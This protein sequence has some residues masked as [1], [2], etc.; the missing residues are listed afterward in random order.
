MQ[1]VIYIKDFKGKK[2][3][4]IDTVSNNVAHGLFELGVAEK[5]SRQAEKLLRRVIK[6]EMRR[7]PKDKMMRAEVKTDGR[8]DKKGRYITK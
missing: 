5:Y 7:P 8:K 4:N 2:R 3:G 6:K 1:R